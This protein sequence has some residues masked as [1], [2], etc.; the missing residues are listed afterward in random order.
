MTVLVFKDGRFVVDES[1]PIEGSLDGLYALIAEP[2][3]GQL[4][5]FNGSVWTSA[6]PAA[7]VLYAGE[8]AAD[9]DTVLSVTYNQIAAAVAA[10]LGVIVKTEAEGTVTLVPLG[11]Y[12]GNA[13][14]GYTVTAGTDTYTA[15]TADG[16]LVKQAGGGAE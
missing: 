16:P 5:T 8:T 13:E 6:A 4:L 11:S 10:G 1:G 12:G 3:A 14:T 9:D 15:E 7:S 2:Q